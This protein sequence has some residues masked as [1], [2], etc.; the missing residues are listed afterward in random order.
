MSDVDSTQNESAQE[1]NIDSSFSSDSESGREATGEK[2]KVRLLESELKYVK[3]QMRM[4]KRELQKYKKMYTDMAQKNKD[5]FEL[6]V[7]PLRAEL[8]LDTDRSDVSYGDLS[9]RSVGPLDTSQEIIP[10]PHQAGTPKRS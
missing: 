2:R 7:R 10:Y 8:D 1:D 9:S 6:G 3:Q 5:N 4:C